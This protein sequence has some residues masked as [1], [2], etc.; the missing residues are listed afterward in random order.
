M[1]N[2]RLG[3][4]TMKAKID[5]PYRVEDWRRE[6]VSKARVSGSAISKRVKVLGVGWKVLM[7][8]MRSVFRVGKVDLRKERRED[9][10]G[11][12]S[13]VR[14]TSMVRK[15]VSSGVGSPSS[16]MRWKRL[17][18]EGEERQICSEVLILP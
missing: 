12:L 9:G 11:E 14:E 13:L 2:E 17:M 18:E 1:T 3:E 15:A 6:S 8:A 7:G 5:E 4:E 16:S 10:D